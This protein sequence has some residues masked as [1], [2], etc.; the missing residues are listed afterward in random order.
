MKR[1]LYL[2]LLGCI[3]G[4]AGPSTSVNESPTPDRLYYGNAH[5]DEIDYNGHLYVVASSTWACSVI[6]SPNCECMIDYN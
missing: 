6:H 3:A 2:I 5:L 1:L 4:C